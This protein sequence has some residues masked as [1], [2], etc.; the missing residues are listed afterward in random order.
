MR[1]A[2]SDRPAR[3]SSPV[4]V[5]SCAAC[6]TL[7]KAYSTPASTSST[8][9]VRCAGAGER[10]L[11]NEPFAPTFSRRR[12][13][14]LAGSTGISGVALTETFSRLAIVRALAPQRYNRADVDANTGALLDYS[15]QSRFH[16][17]SAG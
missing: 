13:T 6:A 1:E 16:S 8:H 9:E 11:H 12:A 3:A 4:H 2:K 5:A 14:S 15:T 7:A 17:C 10:R